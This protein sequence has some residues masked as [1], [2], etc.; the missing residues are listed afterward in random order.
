[1][2]A[3]LPFEKGITYLSRRCRSPSRSQRC[4]SNVCG[5]VKRLGSRCMKCVVMLT[6]VCYIVSEN[7]CYYVRFEGG[8]KDGMTAERRLTPGGMSRSRKR[9]TSAGA[10]RIR[11]DVMTAVMRWASVITALC[12]TSAIFS[13]GIPTLPKWCPHQKW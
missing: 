5:L 9:R 10:I 11:R 1:M 4:G 8:K 7:R 6:E 3:L 2:Q 13:H 12:F